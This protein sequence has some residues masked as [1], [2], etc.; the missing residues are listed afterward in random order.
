MFPLHEEKRL[1]QFSV[2][3]LGAIDR[4]QLSA[5]SCWLMTLILIV[6]WNG[7]LRIESYIP[8]IRATK[9]TWLPA[10]TSHPNGN[11]LTYKEYPREPV[12][13]IGLQKS[14]TTKISFF[15]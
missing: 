1:K 8:V 14:V 13:I 5:G 2:F 6:I 4:V 11:S 12:K 7:H 3:P 10:A 15:G 9:E